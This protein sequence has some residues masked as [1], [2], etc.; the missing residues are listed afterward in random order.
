MNA[1]IPTINIS[2]GNICSTTPDHLI[3]YFIEAKSS[4]KTTSCKKRKLDAIK[5]SV[6][7]H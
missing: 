2:A 3:Q 7:N 4:C 1:N 5:A 6:N